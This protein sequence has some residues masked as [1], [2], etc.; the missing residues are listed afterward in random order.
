MYETAHIGVIQIDGPL[1][2]VYVKFVNNESMMR[3]FQPIEGD[4][5]FHH[6]NREI[7]KVTIEITGV[8]TRRVRVSTLPTEVT[9]TQITN[10]ISIC[11]EV[12]KVHEEVW[13]HAYRF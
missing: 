5:E 11:R 4:L 8:G 7:S 10:A 6:E 13:S 12:K 9:A 2:I 3:V 1:R